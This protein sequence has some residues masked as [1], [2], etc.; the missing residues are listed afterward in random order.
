MSTDNRRS[1]LRI[2]ILIPDKVRVELHPV[3]PEL[4]LAMLAGS[5]RDISMGGM[6]VFVKQK[7]FPSV[8]SDSVWTA[9]ITLPANNAAPCHLMVRC[10]IVN[11]RPTSGGYV[12]GVRFLDLESPT[13]A[14]DNRSLWQF[15]LEEQRRWLKVRS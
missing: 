4:G 7:L 3:G 1:T 14:Y 10:N 2:P 5:A 12:C 9:R 15:L 11:C 8:P 13:R 6:A